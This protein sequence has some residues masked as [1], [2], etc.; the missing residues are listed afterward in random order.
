MLPV[1]S[2][3]E[4]VKL[5][6]SRVELGRNGR[7]KLL[8]VVPVLVLMVFYM[9]FI[10]PAS[11][12]ASWDLGV[13]TP[14]KTS[15][16]KAL[17]PP[18]E[19]G[20]E[21]WLKKFK[22]A[23]GMDQAAGV[24]LPSLI[25]RQNDAPETHQWARLEELP[26]GV[27]ERWAVQ[28]PPTSPEGSW[29]HHYGALAMGGDCLGSDGARHLSI[30]EAKTACESHST[31]RGFTLHGLPPDSHTITQV[32]FK[33]QWHLIPDLKEGGQPWLSFRLDHRPAQELTPA[34]PPP[35]VEPLLKKCE[36]VVDASFD[37]G[38]VAREGVSG[39]DA[40]QWPEYS[41]GAEAPHF[42]Y[43]YPREGMLLVSLAP[44]AYYFPELIPPEVADA[45]VATAA[46]RLERSLIAK[47]KA[48]AG[49][50]NDADLLNYR[51]SHGAW[52]GDR[53]A[54][55]RYL[56]DRIQ[57]ITRVPR[58]ALEETQVLRYSPNSGEKYEPH[59][60]YFPHSGYGVQTSNRIATFITFLSDTNP[61]EGGESSLNRAMGGKSTDELCKF[62]LK[63]RPTK[64]AGL[65]FYNMRRNMAF[66]PYS[67]HTG[68]PNNGNTEKWISPQWIRLFMPP[69][70]LPPESR[71]GWGS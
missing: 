12:D 22:G 56:R 60:D 43:P 41:R 27:D 54:P 14:R 24:Q 21:S 7:V 44:R 30:D 11:H 63:V 45:I 9:V 31:C 55:A 47:G 23:T 25:H 65:L 40:K 66:D 58:T 69:E 13:Y 29:S 16:R 4:P 32:W 48:D 67:Q 20:A 36:G 19:G 17:P 62:G 18:G 1:G 39:L 42:E 59:W 10:R 53:D 51:R 15:H 61:G 3:T 33:E 34:Q 8:L 28:A 57:N 49:G 26:N 64:G 46:P 38:R 6:S 50:K 70:G 35:W 52:L 5:G 71:T 68:C 37:I 2:E